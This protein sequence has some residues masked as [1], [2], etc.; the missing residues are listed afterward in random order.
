[1]LDKIPGIQLRQLKE[2]VGDA[3]NGDEHAEQCLRN[4][5]EHSGQAAP[6]DDLLEICQTLVLIRERYDKKCADKN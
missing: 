5:L 1:M 2:W 6:L 3:K 4:V